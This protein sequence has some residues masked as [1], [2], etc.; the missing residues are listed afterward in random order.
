MIF[1]QA[2]HKVSNEVFVWQP[3]LTRCLDATSANRA[4]REL[5]PGGALMQSSTPQTGQRKYM[6]LLHQIV[7]NDSS[8]RLCV[9]LKVY[10]FFSL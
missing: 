10:V 9:L 8:V 1:L 6:Y 2:F 7:G 5:T 4:L 3:S